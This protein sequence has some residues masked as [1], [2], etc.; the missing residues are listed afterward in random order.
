MILLYGQIIS[1]EFRYR[2][3]CLLFFAV[4]M[5]VVSRYGEVMFALDSNILYR[6]R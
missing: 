1:P 4:H 3:F 6:F 5:Y 2:V